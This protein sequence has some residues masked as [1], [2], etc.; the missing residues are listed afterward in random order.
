MN[1]FFNNTNKAIDYLNKK[2][3]CIE[4]IPN[5]HYFSENV[6]DDIIKYL[7][8]ILNHYNCDIFI[9]YGNE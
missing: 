9:Q 2:Y 5:N 1:T 7:E 4:N 6:K 8:N 3:K